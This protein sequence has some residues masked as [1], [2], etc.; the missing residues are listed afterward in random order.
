MS[1][2]VKVSNVSQ[3]LSKLGMVKVR[4]CKSGMGKV[5]MVKVC[6]ISPV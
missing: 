5:G 4:Y 3:E 2:K 1:G 6:T